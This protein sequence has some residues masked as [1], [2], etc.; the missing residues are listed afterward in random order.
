MNT[1]QNSVGFW[2]R[3]FGKGPKKETVK[4]QWKQ[5]WENAILA[6]PCGYRFS[7]LGR[8]LIVVE[9]NWRKNTAGRLNRWRSA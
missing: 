4:P 7:H 3:I 6:F 5:D 8:E 9:S 2:R 1:E